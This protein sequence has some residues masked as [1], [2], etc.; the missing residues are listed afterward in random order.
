MSQSVL[1]TR[2]ESTPAPAAAGRPSLF[3]GRKG[4]R[5][6]EALLAYLFLLPAFII[7]FTFGMFPLAF[8]A[9]ESTL[10]GLNK[11]VGRY[12]GLANYVKAVDNLAYVL[13]F[14]ISVAF[15]I[16][17]VSKIISTHK[18]AREHEDKPWLWLAPGII[19]G[20]AIALGSRF[21]FAALPNIL[22]IPSQIPRGTELTQRLF[23]SKIGEVMRMEA[24]RSAMIQAVAV[25]LVA[26]LAAYLVNRL[27]KVGDR[28]GGY[29]GAF[30]QSSLLIIMAV[31]LTWF[32]VSEVVGA[33]AAALETGEELAIWSQVITIS[34]GMILLAIAWFIWRSATGLS[35]TRLTV[36]RLLAAGV[37]MIGGWILI[38]ELPRVI[39]AGDKDWWIGLRNT[40][41][42][43]VGTVPIQFAISLVLANLLFQNTVGKATFRMIYFL[44]YIAP[45]VGT[46]SVFRILF[47]ERPDAVINSLIK[48]L[49]FGLAEPLRWLNEPNG[50]FQM[51]AGSNI[52]L[53]SWA[54]GPSLSL[55]VIIIFNIWSYIGYDIVIFMAG[56]GNIPGELY[57]AA[58]IDGSDRW[59]QFRH[60]TLPLLS[61]TIYFLFLLA[62]IGTFKAFNH[63][64]VMRSRA[65]LGTAD[66]AS[67]VIFDAFK[68]DTRYGYASSL[69][70]MLLIIII[71]LTVVNNRIASKRVFYG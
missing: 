21:V 33:Y 15:V 19:M 4:R 60:I 34:G 9:Y 70:V 59:A 8:S 24:V 35:S 62:V 56:L 57:E 36:L 17:A 32:T 44:P 11:I 1:T 23:F 53:P 65:A 22:L 18:L 3:S 6:K 55:V 48:T 47:S 39:A 66:T 45:A 2:D 25:F 71:V 26:V 67:I 20:T 49:S 63:I 58:Q 42:F 27:V 38:A 69:A 37:L 52:E 29:F 51:I 10:R 28:G 12:D 14:W 54:I 43:V 41:Y 7:I 31:G 13:G 46:A 68:R 61:P 16:M 30:T 50:I 64:Y 5:T 40:V